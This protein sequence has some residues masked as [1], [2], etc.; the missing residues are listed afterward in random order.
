M[1]QCRHGRPSP[2]LPGPDWWAKLRGWSPEA[3][4]Q[5]KAERAGAERLRHHGGEDPDQQ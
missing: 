3:I 4:A 1:Q 2:P 5:A